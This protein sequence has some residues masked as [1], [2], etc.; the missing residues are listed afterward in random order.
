MDRSMS[1]EGE[2]LLQ[3]WCLL[4]SAGSAGGGMAKAVVAA[5]ADVMFGTFLFLSH[6]V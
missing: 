1:S 6:M 3:T 4:M 2:C 5:H